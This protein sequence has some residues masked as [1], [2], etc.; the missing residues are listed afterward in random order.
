MLSIKNHLGRLNTMQGALLNEGELRLLPALNADSDPGSANRLWCYD[1]T[2]PEAIAQMAAL[3]TSQTIY[4]PFHPL[5]CA[6]RDATRAALIVLHKATAHD[7]EI[8]VCAC[9]GVCFTRTVVRGI[10]RWAFLQLDFRRLTARV[11]CTDRVKLEYVQRL[12][13]QFEGRQR[14][15]FADDVDATLWGMTRDECPWIQRGQ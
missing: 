1:I 14:K 13:F 5:Y 15:Y 3:W 6:N 12:G 4:R 11:P 9:P 10:A 2:D 7:A 8:I